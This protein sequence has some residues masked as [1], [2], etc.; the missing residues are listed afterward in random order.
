ML[1]E[2]CAKTAAADEE[3]EDLFPRFSAQRFAQTADRFAKHERAI[4]VRPAER[5]QSRGDAVRLEEVL[6]GEIRRDLVIAVPDLVRHDG[7]PSTSPRDGA[8]AS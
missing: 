2:L 7:R 8:D 3:P 5:S 6:R 4:R 1:V